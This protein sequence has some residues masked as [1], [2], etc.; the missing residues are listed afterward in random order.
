MDQQGRPFFWLGDTAWLLGTKLK[1]DE[2]NRYMENRHQKGFTVVQMMVLPSVSST[3]VYGDSALINKNVATPKVTSGHNYRDSVEYDYW[4]NIDY[5]I[6]EA[7]K[8][9]L[10]VALVC[11]WGSNVESGKVNK[12]Q[13][14]QYAKFLAD[15]YKR[16]SNIFWINGG[17]THGSDQT[18]IWN[19]IG[20]T[21]KANDPNHLITF[22]PY[23]R[24]MSSMWFHDA[25]WLDFNMFQSGHRRYD[26]DDTKLA[27]GEDNWRYVKIDY[28]KRPIKP[29]LDGEPSYENIPQELHDTSQPRWKAR[30]VRRYAYWS[31]FAGA[32]GF[33]YGDNG[34]MQMFKPGKNSYKSSMQK[35]NPNDRGAYGVKEYWYNAMNDPGA[36]QMQYLKKLILSRPYFQRIPD[37]SLVV[38]QGQRYNHVAATRGKNYAFIY[39]YNG[40]KMMI[41]MGV[42]NGDSVKASWYNPRNGH[43]KEF[44]VFKNNG[45]DKFNPPGEKKN[46]NDWVLILDSI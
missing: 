27:F 24:T 3:N 40:R 7:E 19:I 44:G 33:T 26:Q 5:I 30:D 31:V 38:H 41:N 15:R 43:S 28:D 2:V 4:D 35:N 17:D 6:K 46:G 42:I 18:V 20:N 13:A 34:V 8:Y 32:C 14:R 21:L 23:G 1:R 10:Y 29:T 25:K 36:G 22:H 39:T 16:Y 37:P 12:R 45:F 11:I 9:H